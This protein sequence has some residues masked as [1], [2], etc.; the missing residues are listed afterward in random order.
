MGLYRIVEI[1]ASK[2][3]PAFNYWAIKNKLYYST[4]NLLSP[5]AL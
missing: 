5:Q 4:K 2:L 3:A 1:L